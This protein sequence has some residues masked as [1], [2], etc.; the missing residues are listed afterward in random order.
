MFAG[1]PP[2]NAI[3][4]A[5][6][7]TL[8]ETEH[9]QKDS[10][11]VAVPAER[12]ARSAKRSLQDDLSLE[13]KKKRRLE[14]LLLQSHIVPVAHFGHHRVVSVSKR[15]LK[16]LFNLKDETSL[17]ECDEEEQNI[18][19]FNDLFPFN[20]IYPD[21]SKSDKDNDDDKIDIKKSSG[22]PR[23][24]E[25]DKVGEVSTIWNSCSLNQQ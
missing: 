1:T 22:G 6:P 10:Q 3:F 16:I 21:D 14:C 12:K 11:T 17:S 4:S 23:W 9:P 24:K 2:D 18:L 8:P 20:V 13:A 25:I 15:G 7:R 5:I 19:Y